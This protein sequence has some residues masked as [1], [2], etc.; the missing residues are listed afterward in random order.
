MITL[1]NGLS[2]EVLSKRDTVL[3]SEDAGKRLKAIL[4]KE[5]KPLD[6]DSRKMQEL[7][8]LGGW[9]IKRIIQQLDRIERVLDRKDN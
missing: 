5:E 4:D 6:A 2:L 7:M 3:K 8:L 9:L 1:S